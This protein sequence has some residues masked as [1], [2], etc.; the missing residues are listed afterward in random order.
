[1]NIMAAIREET[2]RLYG[3][4]SKLINNTMKSEYRSQE[5]EQNN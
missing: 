1:V 4:Q 3:I 2:R 5:S